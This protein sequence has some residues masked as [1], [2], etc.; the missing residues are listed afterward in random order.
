MAEGFDASLSPGTDA[1]NQ[2]GRDLKA[3]GAKELT[4]E[5]RATGR[6]LAK[7]FKDEVTQQAVTILP[8]EGD[9]NTWVSKRIKI[10]AQ[11]RIGGSIS[12]F[13]FVTKHKGER[14]LSDLRSL[15]NGRIRHPLFGNRDRWYLQELSGHFVDRALRE[16][17]DTIREEFLQAVDDVARRLQ[18]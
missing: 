13:R 16:M 17:S 3:A 18:G 12:T 4:K 10:T 11:T 7:V 14:G 8:K 6:R 9:L 1:F 15:N 2:L 5:L